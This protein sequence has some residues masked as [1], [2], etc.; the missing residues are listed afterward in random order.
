MTKGLAILYWAI[1]LLHAYTGL[2]VVPGVFKAFFAIG[3]I[4]FTITGLVLFRRVE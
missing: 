2:I 1:A 3:C 4:F